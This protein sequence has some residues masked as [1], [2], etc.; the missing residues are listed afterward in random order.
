MGEERINT[1]RLRKSNKILTDKPVLSATLMTG[2][3]GSE[4]LEGSPEALLRLRLLRSKLMRLLALTK[5]Q[6]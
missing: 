4:F 5:V 3:S 6:W 1:S 2:Y